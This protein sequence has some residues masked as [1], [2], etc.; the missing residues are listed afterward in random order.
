MMDR[1]KQ[2]S[3]AKMER[4]KQ[5]ALELFSAHGADKVSMDEIAAKA[6]VSKVTIYKY[7]GSKEDL[8]AQVIDLFVDKTLAAADDLLNREMDFLEKLKLLLSSQTNAS[9]WVSFDE[10][11]RVWEQDGQA[12][13]NVGESV[14]TR[15]KAVM[16]RFYEEGKREG[17]ID[18][19]VS[20]DILYLYAE[21]FRAGFKVLSD[22]LES[23]L[24]NQEMREQLYDLYFFGFI[25]RRKSQAS[26]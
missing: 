1:R 12:V 25:N 9:Q 6:N 21:I 10:L 26:S 5:A 23:M 7:F 4:V 14:Q 24:A 8:Y 2:R 16:Y 19:D 20:I 11:F 15:V 17:Y 13:R 3:S 18:E 22:D